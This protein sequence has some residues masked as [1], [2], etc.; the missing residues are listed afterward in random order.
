MWTPLGLNRK[1]LDKNRTTC[2]PM[3]A[4]AY[5]A[6]RIFNFYVTQSFIIVY[7]KAYPEPVESTGHPYIIFL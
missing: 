1:L 3:C 2:F 5:L 4:M 7:T 6:K